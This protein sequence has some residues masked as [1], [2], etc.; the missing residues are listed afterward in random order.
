VLFLR[1]EEML[2][3]P[4]SHVKKLAKFMGCGFSKEGEKGGVV[5][6]S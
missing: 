1:H 5:S 3:E 2:L 4:E 6:V